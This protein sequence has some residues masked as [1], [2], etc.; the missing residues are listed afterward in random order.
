M[1]NSTNFCDFGCGRGELLEALRSR[2][3]KV[4]GIELRE[5]FRVDLVQKGI[6]CIENLESLDDETL[7]IL[8]GFH[9]IE[10]VPNPLQ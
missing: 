6:Q 9:S 3:R 10:H 7:D 4:V 5:D 2:C 8:V 1:I